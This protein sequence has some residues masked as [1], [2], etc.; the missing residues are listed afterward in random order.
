MEEDTKKWVYWAIPVVVAVGI[1]AALYYGR[2]HRQAE[3]AKQTPAVTE[4]RP[5]R[6][7]PS[8][9]SRNPVAET[10]P[11]KPL[12]ELA[13]SDPSTAGGTRRRIRTR[14]RSVPRAEKHHSSHGG[15]DRQSAAQEDSGTD[16]AGEAASAAS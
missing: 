2:V 7:R 4:P 12:P 6:R 8:R 11:P 15:D 16:V 10:P 1:G 14:A 9:R 13:D 3:Q 5:R